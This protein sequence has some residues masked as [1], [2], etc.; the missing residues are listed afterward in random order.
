VISS[1]D[2]AA[3]Y[4]RFSE[5]IADANNDAVIVPTKRK[6]PQFAP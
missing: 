2:E 4:E 5:T 6:T 1:H 3:N